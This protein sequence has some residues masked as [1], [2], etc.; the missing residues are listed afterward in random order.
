MSKTPR[1][2][3]LMKEARGLDSDDDGFGAGGGGGGSRRGGSPATSDDSGRGAKGKKAR[4]RAGIGEISRLFFR[5]CA[6]PLGAAGTYLPCCPPLLEEVSVTEPTTPLHRLLST[7]RGKR[8]RVDATTS[9]RQGSTCSTTSVAAGAR[10]AHAGPL[11]PLSF[12]SREP[13]HV[14]PRPVSHPARMVAATPTR[15]NPCDPLPLRFTL[16]IRTHPSA[17]P[18]PSL[19]SL[20]V[21]RSPR[22]RGPRAAPRRRK[23]A[24]GRTARATGTTAGPR[25]TTGAPGS[26]ARRVGTGGEER[27]RPFRLR[28]LFCWVVGSS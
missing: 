1:G 24:A 21:G 17:Y 3:K 2:A 28:S 10:R 22:P 4:S 27:T 6:K 23:A 13:A 15:T 19:R 11:R 8:A 20:R 14:L 5:G 12:T 9:P 18:Y 25:G 7:L 26:R 16:R